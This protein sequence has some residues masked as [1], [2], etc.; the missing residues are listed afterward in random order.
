MRAF[1]ILAA[2]AAAVPASAGAQAFQHNFT[3]TNFNNWSGGA[4][5]VESVTGSFGINWNPTTRAFSLA[6]LTLEIAGARY[7]VTNSNIQLVNTSNSRLPNFLIG[8]NANGSSM[9]GGTNDFMLA[10]ISATRSIMDFSYTTAGTRGSY[11]TTSV[12]MLPF[13]PITSGPA[14]VPEPATWAMMIGGFGL[15]G[16][17]MRRRAT[18]ISYAV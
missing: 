15:V 4:I 16:G 12:Q 9:G 5:P 17:A 2:L 18:R 3:A 13:G 7:D 14:A 1:V 8:G 11:I 10:Y 6:S